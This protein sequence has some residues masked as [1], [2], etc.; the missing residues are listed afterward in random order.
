LG[1]TST[2][3]LLLEVQIPFPMLLYYNT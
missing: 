1:Q 3:D 2:L